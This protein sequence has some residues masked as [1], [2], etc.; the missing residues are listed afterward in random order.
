MWLVRGHVARWH[1]AA[2]GAAACATV[3][4]LGRSALVEVP[5]VEWLVPL[6]VLVALASVTTGAIP[7]YAAFGP[8]E[9]TLS[10]MHQ[11]RA[12]NVCFAVVMMLAA[13]APALHHP[14]IAALVCVIFSATIAAVVLIGDYAWVVGLSLGL[15]AV[16]ADGSVGKP[17]TT[18]L[19]AVPLS[20]C[21]ALVGAMALWYWWAGARESRP[22]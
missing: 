19:S 4:L 13:C 14:G 20:A 16:M 11:V 21:V 1:W 8:L 15:V 6:P 10:R 18:A 2:L 7:L 5:L 12:I 3:G 22:V 9:S 17:I